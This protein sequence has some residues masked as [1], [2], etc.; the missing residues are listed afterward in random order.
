MKIFYKCRCIAAEVEIVV[1]DRLPG[2]D[3]ADWMGAVQACLGMDHRARSPRCMA[4]ALEYAKIP[5]EGGEVGT[6]VRLQ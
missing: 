5:Y 1:P 2:S 6:P 4:S 3:I